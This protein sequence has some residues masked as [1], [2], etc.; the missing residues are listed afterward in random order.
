MTDVIVREKDGS[1]YHCY[2][3]DGKNA[4]VVID[5]MKG[6][7]DIRPSYY[8]HYKVEDAVARVKS[9]G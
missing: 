1:T 3:D 7:I 6:S 4:I 8:G 2:M 9:L 5:R